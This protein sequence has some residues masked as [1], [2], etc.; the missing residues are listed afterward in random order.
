MLK[1][2][3]HSFALCRLIEGIVEAL[4]SNKV[5]GYEG[6]IL[7]ISFPIYVPVNEITEH[8]HIFNLG[9]YTG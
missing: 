9:A 3:P 4:V 5:F 2:I 8:R 6:Y 7:I 1:H